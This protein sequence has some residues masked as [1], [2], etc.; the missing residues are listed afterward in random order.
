MEPDA[1]AVQRDVA[2]ALEEDVGTGDINA[3]LIDPGAWARARIVTRQAGVLCGRPWA[4]AACGHVDARIEID[5]RLV[6]G[7]ALRP[8]DTLVELRGPA[9]GLLTAE[10]TVINFLQL[11]SGTAT[12]ARR[13]SDAVAGTG[14]IILDTRK[15]LPGLRVAQKYAVRV[16]GAT[17][18]RMGLFDAFL[19]KENHIAAAGGIVAAVRAARTQRPGLAVQVEVENAAQLE[20]AIAAK[21]DRVLLDNFSVAEMREAV[22]LAAGRVSLEAS[23]GITL[24]TVGAIAGTGV[25]FISVGD[26]TKHVEPLDLSMRLLGS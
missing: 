23:G 2:A 26:M 22:G 8:A 3:A 6:D 7:D 4:D 14:A 5:W 15:T 21:A 1:D 25:D 13:Y 9:R 24:D 10:R 17:N 18:H 12:A 11:L 19:L 16:G 20:E